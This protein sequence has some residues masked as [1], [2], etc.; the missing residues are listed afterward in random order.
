MLNFVDFWTTHFIIA[1]FILHNDNAGCLHVDLNFLVF[2]VMLNC[3]MIT[4]AAWALQRL[5]FACMQSSLYRPFLSANLKCCILLT[6]E[7]I[8]SLLG[9]YFSVLHSHLYLHYVCPVLSVFIVE[10]HNCQPCC[11]WPCCKHAFLNKWYKFFILHCMQY[12]CDYACKIWC[13]VEL[14]V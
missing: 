7:A 4:S 1:A 2:F 5:L 9:I 8:G 11:C 3:I 14:S 13:S 6:I 12:P 10:L